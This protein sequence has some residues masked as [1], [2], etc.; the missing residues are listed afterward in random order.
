MTQRRFILAAK[1]LLVI[2][3]VATAVVLIRAW[4]QQANAVLSCKAAFGQLEAHNGYIQVDL[5]RQHPTEQYFDAEVFVLYANSESPPEQL[6]LTREAIG[7]YARSVAEATLVPFGD[8][9]ATPKPFD[10][11]LPTPNISQRL[12]P[13]DSPIFNIAFKFQPAKRQFSQ[14][15]AMN[16]G[17]GKNLITT[18]FL[19]RF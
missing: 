18:C 6:R 16:H 14:M 19:H 11:S 5:L 15:L 7:N 4:R 10:I 3:G 9:K 1:C 13:F 12:F 17:S 2:G 8:G